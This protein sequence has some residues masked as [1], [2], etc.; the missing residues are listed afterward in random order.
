MNRQ[1]RRA[2][3]LVMSLILM[4]F[5]VCQAQARATLPE[6]AVPSGH[7]HHQVTHDHGLSQ[8]LSP[9]AASADC[10]GD[11][12]HQTAHPDAGSTAQLPD[13]SPILLVW[14][15]ATLLPDAAASRALAYQAPSADMADPPPIIRFQRFLN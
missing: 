1:P 15:P 9:D 12:L 14:L 4:I 5:S 2:L 7:V 8:H 11:C 10:H 3:T 6:M 13:V